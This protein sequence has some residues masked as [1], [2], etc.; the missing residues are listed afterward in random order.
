MEKMRQF[1][2]RLTETEELDRY[3]SEGKTLTWAPS[4]RD[5]ART[6]RHEARSW[7]HDTVVPDCPESNTINHPTDVMSIRWLSSRSPRSPFRSDAIQVESWS[8]FHKKYSSKEFRTANMSLL[9]IEKQQRRE[10]RPSLCGRITSCF[11]RRSDQCGC[12]MPSRCDGVCNRD[13]PIKKQL[14]P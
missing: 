3:E 11:R 14:L 2:Q 1:S 4:V 6:S 5:N 7:H 9:E 13:S 10:R 8:S 12:G